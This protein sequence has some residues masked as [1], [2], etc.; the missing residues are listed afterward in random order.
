MAEAVFDGIEN[1]NWIETQWDGSSPFPSM[2]FSPQSCFFAFFPGR[3][4]FLTSGPVPYMSLTFYKIEGAV[5]NICSW[6]TDFVLI[7]YP[8]FSL[9]EK[10][11]FQRNTFSSC[12]QGLAN[13]SLKILKL[14]PHTLSMYFPQPHSRMILGNSILQGCSPS[15]YTSLSFKMIF[16]TVSLPANFGF[17][18]SIEPHNQQLPNDSWHFFWN[19]SI[20]IHPSDRK[21]NAYVS[22]MCHWSYN[23]ALFS[24]S[25]YC[26]SYLLQK[27]SFIG[28]VILLKEIFLIPVLEN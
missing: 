15:R 6:I 19:K 20:W 23:E 12:N 25:V 10:S 13:L 3:Q 16:F 11:H 22:T 18:M 4:N 1:K 9:G 2:Q 24:W 27:Y 14:S 17:S 26:F 8:D 21:D 7:L 5:D 28:S